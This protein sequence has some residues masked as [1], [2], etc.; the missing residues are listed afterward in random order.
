MAGTVH[1]AIA[2]VIGELPAVGKDSEIE[3]G[4]QRYRYRGIEAIK[5]ALKPVLAAAGVHYTLHRLVAVV[6]DTVPVGRQGSV[7][8]RTRLQARWRIYGPEGDHV[9][10]ETRGEGIDS[11]DK[12]ANKAV[13]VAEKQMLLTTFCVADGTEDPDHER[14][15]ITD[16][17]R[18]GWFDGSPKAL[19]FAMVDAI[20]AEVTAGDRGRALELA[21]KAWEILGLE[22]AAIE[23]A[24]VLD[25]IQAAVAIAYQEI[26]ADAGA[27]EPHEAPATPPATEAEAG[28]S[29]SDNGGVGSTGTGDDEPASPPISQTEAVRRIKMRT[30]V[31][32]L[33]EP[34]G[35]AQ[36][37]RLRQWMSRKGWRI[38][39]ITSD[40]LGDVKAYITG[41]VAAMRQ[42]DDE[43]EP[44]DQP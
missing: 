6:D 26:A 42:P 35:K 41:P 43:P 37:A 32:D 25:K 19:K 12:A 22:G 21:A 11:S 23:A 2:E 17:P 29:E 39:D 14:H 38:D 31:R 20:T 30:E 10:V 1:E 28:P 44:E 8:Q 36:K 33:I 40:E 18:V 24:D 7:W 5:A 9:T 13:T 16:R 4:P 27:V 3:S 15:E 34:L